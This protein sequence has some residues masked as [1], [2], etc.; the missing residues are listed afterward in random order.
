MVDTILAHYNHNG[1]YV[2]TKCVENQQLDK[3]AV[4]KYLKKTAKYYSYTI[5][6]PKWGI[7]KLTYPIKYSVKKNISLSAPSSLV[8]LSGLNSLSRTSSFKNLPNPRIPLPRAN[9]EKW[10]DKANFYIH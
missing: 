3:A 2:F 8:Q 1:H 6:E 5:G 7:G 10:S 9:S 4:E